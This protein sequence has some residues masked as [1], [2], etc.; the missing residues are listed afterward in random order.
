MVVSSLSTKK[1]KYLTSRSWSGRGVAL[2]K[3]TEHLA[4]YWL[5]VQVTPGVEAQLFLSGVHNLPSRGLTACN[6][7][8]LPQINN[9]YSVL[10]GFIGKKIIYLS[11]L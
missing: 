8:K 9:Q 5:W 11:F 3:E 10:K 4:G 6:D 1:K 7:W 2:L